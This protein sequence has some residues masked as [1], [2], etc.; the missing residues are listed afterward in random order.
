MEIW[1]ISHQ[2]LI[3]GYVPSKPHILPCFDGLVLPYRGLVL[4]LTLGQHQEPQ[5]K[6]FVSLLSHLLHL[7]SF[8]FVVPLLPIQQLVFLPLHPPVC[9][10]P[11]NC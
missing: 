6:S 4:I 8:L 11:L 7:S 3:D 5:V 2:D 1:R 9:H 10:A